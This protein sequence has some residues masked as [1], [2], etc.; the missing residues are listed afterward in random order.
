ML[1][2]I[3]IADFFIKKAID[4]K[5][6]GEYMSNLKLQKLMYY[7]YVWLFVFQREHLF[8]EK[9]EAWHYGPVVPSLYHNFKNG[10]RPIEV[11]ETDP[12][13]LPDDTKEYLDSIWHSYGQYS[14]EALINIVHK[15][16]PWL[17]AYNLNNTKKIITD[18]SILDFYTESRAS[19]LLPI[20]TVITL[21]NDKKTLMPLNDEIIRRIESPEYEEFD[22]N[23]L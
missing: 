10:D 20:N 9:L 13:L 5:F 12:E 16:A 23:A 6:K 8:E 4:N 18:E 1:D 3:K 2:N 11:V 15:E 21:Y 14:A 7:A 19:N 17:D 22:I